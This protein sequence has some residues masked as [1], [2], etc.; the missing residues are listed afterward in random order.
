V[1]GEVSCDRECVSV[2]EVWG[3]RL[4]TEGTNTM[5]QAGMKYFLSS[6]LVYIRPLCNAN[7]CCSNAARHRF[8]YKSRHNLS[9]P[10][11]STLKHATPRSQLSPLPC[12][13]S[14]DIASHLLEDGPL[15]M[16][17]KRQYPSRR[18]PHTRDTHW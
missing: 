14:R 15:R 5:G 16:R 3:R 18:T 7:Q 10:P 6:L 17:H 12:C 13:I 9:N 2:I 8:Q 4:S 11:P 1:G